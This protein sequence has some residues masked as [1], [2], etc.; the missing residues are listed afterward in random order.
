MR[1]IP[2]ISNTTKA[3][4]RLRGV[5]GLI[6]R[7]MASSYAISWMGM[8]APRAVMDPLEGRRLVYHQF[9]WQARPC[10]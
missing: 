2:L 9:H 3:L 1:F 4:A 7:S 10:R 5:S 8:T 6:Q